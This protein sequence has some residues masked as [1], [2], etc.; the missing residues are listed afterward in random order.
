MWALRSGPF[1]SVDRERLGGRRLPQFSSVVAPTWTWCAHSPSTMTE[2]AVAVPR[3]LTQ[4]GE[5][6]PGWN[7]HANVRHCCVECSPHRDPPLGQMPIPIP[8][9]RI[10]RV[11]CEERG[12][13]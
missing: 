1:L 6:R 11:Q 12:T 4:E 9:D 5:Q 3:T 8:R 13:A 7:N 2:L 10:A